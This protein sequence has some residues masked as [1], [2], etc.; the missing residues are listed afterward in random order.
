[1]DCLTYR[2]QLIAIM[3]Q[4]DFSMLDPDYLYTLNRNTEGC[5]Y[6]NFTGLYMEPADRLLPEK[7]R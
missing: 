2:F 6:D 4:R 1:M 3:R 7:L 5:K